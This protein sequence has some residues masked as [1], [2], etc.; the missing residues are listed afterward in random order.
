MNFEEH[1]K[2]LSAQFSLH[3]RVVLEDS[4]L[5]VIPYLFEQQI[6][7]GDIEQFQQSLPVSQ[8]CADYD[9]RVKE[10]RTFSY[11]VFAPKGCTRAKEALLLLHGLN[12][13]SWDKYLPW[14]ED[15]AM[16]CDRP[17]ILFPIA[18]HMNRTPDTWCQ[19]RWLMQWL[20]RRKQEILH[21]YNAS[22]C[23][24]ALSSRL[25]QSPLRFYVS[26]RESAFNIWQLVEQMKQGQHPLFAEDC[27]VDIF[28]YSIGALLSQVLLMSNPAH[29]FDTS[30]LFMFC[31]GSIFEKMNGNARDIMDQKA[32]DEIKDFYLNSFVHDKYEATSATL[33][34]GDSFETS[35]K[36]MIDPNLYVAPR[37]AFFGSNSDRIRALTLAKDR[38]IP[39]A[40]VQEAFGATASTTMLEERDFPFEYSHQVPFPMQ[41]NIADADVYGCFRHVFNTAAAFLAR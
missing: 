30:K 36:W 35:F 17:V 14:A 15:L 27:H 26:G 24:V 39:T 8:L 31:G 12:E 37:E 18:F 2:K 7:R 13:R 19:P 4:P 29:L 38:V 20:N 22:F 16:T 34:A 25:T 40:G 28:A 21:L 32:Y 33:F 41:K 11:T 9:S 10:N 5:E 1:T 23:N 3:Q 6:G